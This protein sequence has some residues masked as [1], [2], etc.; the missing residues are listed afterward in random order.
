LELK[1]LVSIDY[2]ISKTILNIEGNIENR[3]K[4]HPLDQKHVEIGR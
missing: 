2:C 4:H 3:E 1:Y